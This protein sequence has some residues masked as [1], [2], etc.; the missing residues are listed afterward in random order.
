MTSRRGIAR[1]G[2]A[3][4]AAGIIGAS[5]R[6]HFKCALRSSKRTEPRFV[7]VAVQGRRVAA[8]GVVCFTTVRAVSA[9]RG[10]INCE[11]VTAPVQGACPSKTPQSKEWSRRKLR[12]DLWGERLAPRGHYSS[13][14]VS[15]WPK[16]KTGAARPALHIAPRHDHSDQ[17][18]DPT[19]ENQTP[20]R[21]SGPHFHH[22]I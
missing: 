15:T 1:F 13:T 18:I 2:A 9:S 16:P 20:N 12:R 5:A 11:A 21:V 22:H 7:V 14:R 17:R 19:R 3:I 4:G 6:S 8:F 10:Q